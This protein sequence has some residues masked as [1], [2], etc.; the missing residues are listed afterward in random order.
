MRNFS[1]ITNQKG[2]E[3]IFILPLANEILQPARCSRW[4][5]FVHKGREESVRAEDIIYAGEDWAHEYSR[6]SNKIHAMKRRI[7]LLAVGANEALER[8]INLP[9][10]RSGI[11]NKIQ[12]SEELRRR[13]FFNNE[14][15]AWFIPSGDANKNKRACVCSHQRVW[16]SF[17]LTECAQKAQENSFHRSPWG[18]V[19]HQRLFPDLLG[20]PRT[21]NLSRPS[22]PV[23]LKSN[24]F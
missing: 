17:P 6:K 21:S 4:N 10:F 2:W 15:R 3:S 24:N 14:I 11:M 5:L 9:L 16:I 23:A 20:E 13:L 22:S 12:L 7:T 19:L 8:R 18:G 1:A